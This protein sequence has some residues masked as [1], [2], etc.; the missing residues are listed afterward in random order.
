MTA[1]SK[2]I[3][4][5]MAKAS[6]A[7]IDAAF[8]LAGILDNLGRGYWQGAEGASTFFDLDNEAHTRFL[9]ER[10]LKLER[11]GSLF[12]VVG[13]LATLLN[14]E[15]AIVDPDDD[16][17]ALH[18]RFRAQPLPLAEYHEDMGPVIWWRFP[19]EE[20]AWIGAPGDS[21]WPGYHTHFTPHP[22]IPEAPHA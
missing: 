8:E 13:G 7:D 11:R 4:L 6:T 20:P 17:I 16:C 2:T 19:V 12:R 1:D 21:D 14:P 10:L 18:P 5:R 22:A 9:A 15:N 3:P